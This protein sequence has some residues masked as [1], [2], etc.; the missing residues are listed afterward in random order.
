M[1]TPSFNRTD[2]AVHRVLF[3]RD[4]LAA[5]P[6]QQ[7]LSSTT[8]RNK[9][10]TTNNKQRPLPSQPPV[11]Q[12]GNPP[13]EFQNVRVSGIIVAIVMAAPEPPSERRY[14]AQ[15]GEEDKSRRLREMMFPSHSFVLDDGTGLISFSLPTHLEHSARAQRLV[16]GAMVDVLGTLRKGYVFQ[17]EKQGEQRRWVECTGFS[18]CQDV[19][20]EILRPLEA[21]RLYRDHY[22]PKTSNGGENQHTSN[23]ADGRQTKT[24]PTKRRWEEDRLAFSYAEQLHPDPP[25]H[26][27]TTTPPAPDPPINTAPP[28]PTDVKPEDLNIDDLMDSLLEDKDLEELM[29]AIDAASAA[30][31]N[32]AAITISRPP[33]HSSTM[34]LQTRIEQYLRTAE[35]GANLEVLGKVFGVGEGDV[36]AAV[37]NLVNASLV[38]TMGDTYFAI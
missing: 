28:P 35:T 27:A 3:I 6:V 5:T 18:I 22:F 26:N 30:S 19:L 2:P 7:P 1:S 34:T 14:G 32:D 15:P 13:L 29:G 8:R 10:T 12:I 23:A 11:F 33:A 21:M 9:K 17:G 37:D 4:L 24:I 16:K 36:R 38:Y 25:H 31:A 20:I